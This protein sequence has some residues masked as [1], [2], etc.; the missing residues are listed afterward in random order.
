[1]ET[2][3]AYVANREPVDREQGEG[4]MSANTPFKEGYYIIDCPQDFSKMMSDGIIAGRGDHRPLERYIKAE[5]SVHFHLGIARTGEKELCDYCIVV[6]SGIRGENAFLDT[7]FSGGICPNWG[8]QL[9]FVSRVQLLK[10]PERIKFLVRSVI[11]LQCANLC[12][13]V[14]MEVFQSPERFLELGATIANNEERVPIL[15]AATSECPS[16]IIESAPR[17]V[18]TITNQKGPMFFI[19]R[20][21]TPNLVQVLKLFIIV[22]TDN[23]IGL[24]IEEDR[25]FVVQ[26]FKVF[27]STGQFVPT[28]DQG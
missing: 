26:Q 23:G 13:S 28:L 10:K 6:G 7:G 18:D 1:M 8:E 24:A 27:L 21:G 3:D 19:K 9:V 5:L 11:R 4:E 17:I 12:D 20:F 25:D 15:D 22:V 2:I 14:D 16:E